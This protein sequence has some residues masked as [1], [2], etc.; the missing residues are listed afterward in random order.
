MYLS[1]Y[2]LLT[3]YDYYSI[4][5][6]TFQMIIKTPPLG[7]FIFYLLDEDSLAAFKAALA[8]SIALLNSSL[9]DL[10]AA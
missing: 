1:E 9:A 7:E 2:F 4:L 10:T 8:D 6:F 3:R 5:I